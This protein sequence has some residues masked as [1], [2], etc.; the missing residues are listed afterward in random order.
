MNESTSLF[1]FAHQ[2]DESGVFWELHR[3]VSRGENVIV[4]YLTS[5]DVSGGPSSI[6]DCESISVLKKLGV[7]KKLLI[8]L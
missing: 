3:L 6:R 2:D 1:I 7:L 4:V 8:L 5:G